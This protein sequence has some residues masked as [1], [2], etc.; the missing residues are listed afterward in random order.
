MHS[1]CLS[2]NELCLT[3]LNRRLIAGGLQLPYP[4]YSGGLCS[5]WDRINCFRT[6]TGQT[7]ALQAFLGHAISLALNE[8]AERRYIYSVF[9]QAAE[10]SH[11][12]N[13]CESK[14]NK[15]N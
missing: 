1:T 12:P 3:R 7:G 2:S 15:R 9:R 13:T 4:N 8:I 11:G 10:R 14:N 6:E 5:N